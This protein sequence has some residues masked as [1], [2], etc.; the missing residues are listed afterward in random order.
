MTTPSHATVASA[1]FLLP[2]VLLVLLPASQHLQVAGLLGESLLGQGGQPGRVLLQQLL[3]LDDLLLL[4]GDLA[5]AAR[6]ER[7]AGS[8]RRRLA[9][10]RAADTDSSSSLLGAASASGLG[11]LLDSTLGHWGW[12]RA[13]GERVGGL[14][15]RIA[16][17][18]GASPRWRRAFLPAG[19]ALR[20]TA[21]VAP[22]G[23]ICGQPSPPL[24]LRLSALRLAAASLDPRSIYP[25]LG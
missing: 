3:L 22:A 7:L 18:D 11:L 25:V 6:L 1:S 8:G 2:F 4:R 19:S 13:G 17:G 21:H 12:R 16:N 9:Q 14:L 23:T 24:C 15:E 5:A 10:E 20:L